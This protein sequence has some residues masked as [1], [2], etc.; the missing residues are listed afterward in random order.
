[1]FRASRTTIL[2]SAALLIA[3]VAIACDSKAEKPTAEPEPPTSTPVQEASAGGSTSSSSAGSTLLGRDGRTRD[4]ATDSFAQDLA[5][6]EVQEC[7]FEQL[8]VE[9]DY[10]P[11]NSDTSVFGDIDPTLVAEAFRTCGVAPA[12]RDVPG[13]G[14]A[15]G[16]LIDPEIQECLTEELGEEFGGTLGRGSGIGLTPESIAALE[17]CGLGSGRTGGFRFGGGPDGFG[18]DEGIFGGTGTFQGG[19][20]QECIAEAL[21][22]DQA[23]SL[24]GFSLEITPEL[25]EAFEECGGAIGI[26]VEPDGGIGDGAGPILIEPEVV[27]TEIPVSELSI[28]QLTC[29]SSE[30]EPADLASAVVATSSGDLSEISDEILAALQNCGAV[31]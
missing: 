15:T 6:P 18:R 17:K 10:E 3:I 28:E 2:I 26:P 20:L 27:P 9:I 24:G 23:P 8:G 4:P 29:L 25:Q 14:F 22:Q 12:G 19:A 13:G 16:G 30:L 31:S 1:M 5:D 11:G 21:G 7:L